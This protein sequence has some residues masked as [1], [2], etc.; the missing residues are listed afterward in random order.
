MSNPDEMVSVI[1][2]R[3]G[4]QTRGQI[5]QVGEVVQIA[6]QYVKDG[7][8][9][10][11][12]RLGDDGIPANESYLANGFEANRTK[13]PLL[14]AAEAAELLNISE[15][16]V[17]QLMAK[18][19]IPVV[20]IEGSVRVHRAD[21]SRWLDPRKVEQ[22]LSEGQHVVSSTYVSYDPPADVAA[23]RGEVSHDSR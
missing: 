10:G 21:L 7:V 2:T 3:A 16:T 15:S 11:Y 12:W 5:H 13:S 20:R 9:N 23:F 17:R 1:I 22:E 6:R 18:G 8:A 14:T 4:L 19:L